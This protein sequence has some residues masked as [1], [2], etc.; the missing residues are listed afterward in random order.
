MVVCQSPSPCHTLSLSQKMVL[1][2]TCVRRNDFQVDNKLSLI[3][4]NV[5]FGK[6]VTSLA[7]YR[8]QTWLWQTQSAVT[9]RGLTCGSWPKP[10]RCLEML[11]GWRCF[12]QAWTQIDSCLDFDQ[13]A[14]LIVRLPLVI[15][16]LFDSPTASAYHTSNCRQNLITKMWKTNQRT[17]PSFCIFVDD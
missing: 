7:I 15:S 4:L 12:R 9:W 16:A 2:Q 5:G 17:L 13:N 10:S 6:W 1:H 8:K 14:C 11:F 3:V